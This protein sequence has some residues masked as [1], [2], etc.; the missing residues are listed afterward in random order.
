MAAAPTIQGGPRLVYRVLKTRGTGIA[1]TVKS[2]SSWK[3]GEFLLPTS[4]FQS[5]SGSQWQN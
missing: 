4:A 3:T 2:D 5:V 1:A